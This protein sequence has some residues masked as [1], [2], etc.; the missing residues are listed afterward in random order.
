MRRRLWLFLTLSLVLVAVALVSVRVL[1]GSTDVA[2]ADANTR[3]QIDVEQDSGGTTIFI[4][5][6]SAISGIV[7]TPKPALPRIAYDSTNTTHK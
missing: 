7:T 2:S 6:A 3:I 1:G 5:S 4:G